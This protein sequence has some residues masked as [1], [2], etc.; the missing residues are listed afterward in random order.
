MNG[1]SLYETSRDQK[2]LILSKIKLLI[3]KQIGQ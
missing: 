3:L 1:F 2:L